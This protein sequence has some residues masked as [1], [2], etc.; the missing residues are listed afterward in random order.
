MKDRYRQ[1]FKRLLP[2]ALWSSSHPCCCVP[3]L[4]PLP[5]VKL[6]LYTQE[7]LRM[8]PLND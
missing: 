8:H 1:T 4:P 6:G 3:Q 7:T 5:S 2:K